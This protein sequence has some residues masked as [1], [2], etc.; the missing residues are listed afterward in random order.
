MIKIKKLEFGE[1]KGYMIGKGLVGPPLMS[2]AFYMIDGVLI[3][4]GFSR[5]EKN[6]LE[7]LKEEPPHTILL[8]HFH[9]DHSG[10]AAA[11]KK[12][13]NAKICG[14]LPTARLMAALPKILPYEHLVWGRASESD[15]DPVAESID[16]GR[17]CFTPIYTPG[18]S[19]DHTVYLEK[20]HGWLFSGDLYIAEKIKFFRSDER[21]EDQIDSI[22]KVLEHDFDAIFCGHRPC[23]ENGKASLES[24]LAFLE[25]IRG[26]VGKMLEK[27]YAENQI[28]NFFQD[29]SARTTQLVTM[30]NVSFRNM[31]FSAINSHIAPDTYRNPN[32]NIL[33]PFFSGWK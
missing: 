15:V 5:M 26:N 17:Y 18:H 25:D 3:D 4:T 20:E 8:T 31:I 22:K 9:E 10:N 14:S 33:Y 13:Y 7:L 23:P 16:L 21:I 30:G 1:I 24:K 28:V 12:R 11:I 6:V 29:N 2:A 32:D 19:A 27:G